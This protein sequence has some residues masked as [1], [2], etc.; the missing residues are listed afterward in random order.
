MM[1]LPLMLPTCEQVADRLSEWLDGE[2]ERDVA[3][4]V[5]LH[6]ATCTRCSRLASQLAATV[7]ALHRLRRRREARTPSR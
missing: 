1:S 5:E 2:L 4:R 3:R 7:E 6:L